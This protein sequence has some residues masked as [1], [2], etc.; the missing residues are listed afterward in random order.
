MKKK[1]EMDSQE[2]QKTI[3]DYSTIIVEVA[4]MMSG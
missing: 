4:T 1:K 3:S 2:S